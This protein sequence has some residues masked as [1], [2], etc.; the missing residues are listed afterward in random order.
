MSNSMSLRYGILFCVFVFGCS[1]GL[2]F[3]KRIHK[4]ISGPIVEMADHGG[5]ADLA[6]AAGPP[7]DLKKYSGEFYNITIP[8]FKESR[9][10]SVLVAEKA[11]RKGIGPLCFEKPI[12]TRLS[13]DGKTIINKASSD[14]GWIELST[15]SD[16]MDISSL[17]FRGH[18]KVCQ[19]HD[20]A[21]TKRAHRDST[22]HTGR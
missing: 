11:Y 12:L 17:E 18:V 20:P 1:F 13:E 22:K 8:V 2:I 3:G 5:T 21:E 15:A 10:T 7:T 9:L 14:W 4:F 6:A 19:Y 16:E